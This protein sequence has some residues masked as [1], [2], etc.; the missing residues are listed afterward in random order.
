MKLW[1]KILL[2]EVDEKVG[3]EPSYDQIGQLGSILRVNNK[4]ELKKQVS[5]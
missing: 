4:R 1:I 2:P 5:S 3:L